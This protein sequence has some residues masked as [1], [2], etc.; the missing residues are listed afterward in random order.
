[1]CVES[2]L[3]IPSS[4]EDI[5]Y[6]TDPLT[7]PNLH[8]VLIHVTKYYVVGGNEK[9]LASAPGSVRRGVLQD[10]SLVRCALRSAVP[11]VARVILWPAPSRRRGSRTH[12]P[13]RRNGPKSSLLYATRVHATRSSRP[14]SGDARRP[15]CSC[16]AQPAIVSG[17]N[18]I[19]LKQHDD[20]IMPGGDT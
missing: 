18:R 5:H 12:T 20:I 1:M 4:D 9:M 6:T 11:P 7:V 3:D 16:T 17:D 10:L 8:D 2:E 19:N 13:D 15:A 14:G